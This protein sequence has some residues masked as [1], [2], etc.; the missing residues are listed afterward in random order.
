MNEEVVDEV[1][2]RGSPFKLAEK[3]RRKKKHYQH[4]FL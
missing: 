1:V 2:E 4:H 3:R